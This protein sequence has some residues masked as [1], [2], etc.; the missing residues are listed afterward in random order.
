MTLICRLNSRNV[1]LIACQSLQ[2]AVAPLFRLACFIFC[3][4]KTS[5][6]IVLLKNRNKIAYSIRSVS[7]PHTTSR[8]YCTYLSLGNF[9]TLKITSSAVKEHLLE[10]KKVTHILFFYN[11]CQSHALTVFKMLP[12]CMHARSQSLSPLVDGRVNNVL[13]QTVPDFNKALLQLIDTV[14]MTFMHSLL[15]NTADVIVH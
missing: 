7:T 10:N 1:I 6:F 15:H 11:V 14:H 3:F 2:L 13:S 4:I 9:K 12:I 5:M 8:V